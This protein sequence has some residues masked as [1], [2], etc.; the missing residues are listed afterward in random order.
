MAKVRCIGELRYDKGAF[1]V[2]KIYIK[3]DLDKDGIYLAIGD[4]LVTDN[5][6]QLRAY[7]ECIF[8]YIE[9]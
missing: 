1:T 8:E 5:Y 9:N 7:P 2:G 6:R 3:S 4:I